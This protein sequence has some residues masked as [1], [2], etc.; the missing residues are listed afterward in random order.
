MRRLLVAAWLLALLLSRCDAGSADASGS[1]AEPKADPAG[2]TTDA[3]CPDDL[4]CLPS[5]GACTARGALP[6][7][8][9]LAVVPPATD[10]V[11]DPTAWVQTQWLDL[12][13]GA[14]HER[15][16]T[17]S[18]PLIL[19]GPIDLVGV[20]ATPAN[21]CYLPTSVVATTAADIA[22]WVDYRFTGTISPSLDG[23][24]WRYRLAVPPD[25]LYRI[26]LFLGVDP[27]QPGC[28]SSEADY[29]PVV[30]ERY[31]SDQADRAEIALVAPPL[32]APLEGTL[33]FDDGTPARGVKLVAASL[34]GSTTFASSVTDAE[35]RFALRLPEGMDR[36]ELTARATPD[37]PQFPDQAVD[38]QFLAGDAAKGGF[39]LTLPTLPPLQAVRVLARDAAGAPQADVDVSLA[40]HLAGGDVSVTVTTDAEGRAEVQLYAGGY[41]LVAEPDPASSS[42][43]VA[44]SVQVEGGE[45]AVDLPAKVLAR[46]QVRDEPS[47]GGVGS[48][49]LL[50]S[51]A[52]LAGSEVAVDRGYHLATD[53]LGGLEAWLEPGTWRVLVVPGASS[54]LPR[55][56]LV[57]QVVGPG[58]GQVSVS[59]PAPWVVH[60]RVVDPTGVPVPF[61]AIQALPAD[62]APDVRR[63]M[64]GAGYNE[65]S[66]TTVLG[67][68]VTGA[69][70]RFV[71]A[72]PFAR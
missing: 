54:G 53:D 69:D 6:Y 45:L 9:S 44:A 12:D 8:V 16:L 68:A 39:D 4:A 10:A 59:I 5:V 1:I 35:G 66:L 22:G 67:E 18:T 41:T 51:L 15:N 38:G 13:P 28:P 25:H 40:G 64:A 2:C 32:A 58:G 62:Q 29:P 33:G 31:V 27:G 7:R 72:L 11:G 47:G 34:D 57:D 55:W 42:G 43:A 56:S 46:I 61:A 3:D 48:A 24:G 23:G 30:V 26:T 20:G 60:G 17:L 52:S 36:F 49:E 65:R 70:G 71:L 21:A 14:V 63:A 37:F 50:L 19:E